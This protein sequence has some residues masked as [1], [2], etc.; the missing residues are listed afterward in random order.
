MVI[1]TPQVVAL[2][3]DLMI[4]IAELYTCHWIFGYL[5]ILEDL[6]DPTSDARVQGQTGSKLVRTLNHTILT[7]TA[8]AGQP[9]S[10]QGWFRFS[11]NWQGP[12]PV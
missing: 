3:Q 5:P 6:L 10:T 2:E 11:E 1:T 12:D 8:S 4:S 7:Q 9:C